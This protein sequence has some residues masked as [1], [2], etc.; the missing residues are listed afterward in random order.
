MSALAG[1]FLIAH[2]LVHLAVWVMPQP[3]DMPFDARR[4]WLLGDV[5]A[6]SRLL[7]ILACAVLVAGGATA[8]FDGDFA[9]LAA[10]GAAVSL[11]LLVLTFH[12]WFIAAV[13]I[14][15]AIIAVAIG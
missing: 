3:D 11:A 12:P 9:V 2:G 10:G 1:V 6:L 8:L 13:A 5:P 7:A 15:V 4:S 14:D